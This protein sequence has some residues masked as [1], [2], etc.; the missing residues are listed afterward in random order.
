MG[1]LGGGV[2]IKRGVKLSILYGRVRFFSQLCTAK[3]AV[4]NV[5]GQERDCKSSV[6]T[7][8]GFPNI[9]MRLR[10]GAEERGCG[11]R[12]KKARIYVQLTCSRAPHLQDEYRGADRRSYE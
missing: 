1:C 7:L 8:L 6:P 2:K 4:L 9:A 10:S 11:Y 12:V 3:A 5:C